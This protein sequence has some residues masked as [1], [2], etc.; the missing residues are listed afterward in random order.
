VAFSHHYESLAI[1]TKVVTAS[2]SKTYEVQK[3]KKIG[4]TL[5]FHPWEEQNQYCV[6]IQMPVSNVATSR[7]T[8]T[9][10]TQDT[11]MAAPTAITIF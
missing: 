4:E 7:I 3:G 8:L 11:T 5:P 1:L 10:H 6:N 2:N 9:Y